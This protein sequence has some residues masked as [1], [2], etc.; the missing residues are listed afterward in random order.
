MLEPQTQ[1]AEPRQAAIYVRMSTER[2]N[3]SIAN[4]ITAL[5]QYAEDNGMLIVKRF[6]DSGK[7]GLTLAG[8]PAIAIR[9]DL[10]AG[11]F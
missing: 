8:R 4:Q 11:G 3:Y 2:Q 5:E 10:H 6:V 9:G 1:E 7:S